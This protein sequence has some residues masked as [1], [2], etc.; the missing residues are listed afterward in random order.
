[1]ST[2]VLAPMG[3]A[4]ATELVQAGLQ[5]GGRLLL[6]VAMALFLSYVLFML[7]AVLLSAA[8][9]RVRTAREPFRGG[10][11]AGFRSASAG[12]TE[13]HRIGAQGFR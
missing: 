6:M 7:G 9:D 3:T 8:A 1:M 11:F 10:G 12:A 13:L 4:P 5:D 2:T